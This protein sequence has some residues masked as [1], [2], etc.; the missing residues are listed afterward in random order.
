LYISLVVLVTAVV[1]AVSAGAARADDGGG[2]VVSGACSFTWSAGSIGFSCTAGGVTYQC[3]LQRT[4]VGTL[5]LACSSNGD[6]PRSITCTFRF[7]PFSVVCTK[8]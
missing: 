8:P 7:A 3:S 6:V 1:L 5:V 4:A 2:G